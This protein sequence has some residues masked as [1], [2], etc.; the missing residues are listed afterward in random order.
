[1]TAQLNKLDPVRTAKTVCWWLTQYLSSLNPSF[2]NW[3]CAV[4]AAFLLWPLVLCEAP[5]AGPAERPQGLGGRRPAPSC[6][7]LAL[8]GSSLLQLVAFPEHLEPPAQCPTVSP[9]CALSVTRDQ[10]TETLLRAWVPDP[11]GCSSKFLRHQHQQG[12]F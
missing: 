7:C 11:W 10:L 3:L 2:Y 5:P 6:L 9:Y 8:G 12:P 4:G 1:M